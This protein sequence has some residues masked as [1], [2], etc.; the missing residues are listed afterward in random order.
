MEFKR[1]NSSRGPLRSGRRGH[2]VGVATPKR[3]TTPLKKNSERGAPTPPAA[4]GPA[5]SPAPPLPPRTPEPQSARY[6]AKESPRPPS[7]T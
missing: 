6:S 7:T 1:S 5:A 3:S 2:P 4:A